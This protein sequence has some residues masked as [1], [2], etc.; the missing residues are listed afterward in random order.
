M[1]RD[2]SLGN[3]SVGDETSLHIN[4]RTDYALGEI[5]FPQVGRENQTGGRVWRFGVWVDGAFAWSTDPTFR[6]ALRY[7]PE[8][9]VTDVTLENAALDIVLKCADAVDYHRDIYLRKVTL[10][11][12]RSAPR[13]ARLFFHQN[14][15]LKGSERQNTVVYDPASRSML[16]YR[17]DRWVLAGASNGT[18]YGVDHYGVGLKEVQGLEGV[19]RACETGRLGDTAVQHGSVDSAVELDVELGPSETRTVYFYLCFGVSEAAVRE[20]HQRLVALGPERILE[21]TANFWRVWVTAHR[22]QFADLPEGLVALYRRSLL[23]IRTQ[24]DNSGAIIAAVD[25]DVASDIRENYSYCWTR[26]G[27]LVAYALQRAGYEPPSAAFFDFCLRVLERE[28][29]PYFMHKYNPDDTVASTWLPRVGPHREPRLPI[30]EDE[31]ALV[32][33]SLWEHYA[34]FRQMT[35][36]LREQVYRMVFP[37][38]D[39]IC[40]FRIDGLPCATYDLWEERFGVHLYTAAAVY[41][42]LRAARDFAAVFAEETRLLRYRQAA[43]EVRDAIMTKFWDAERG[44]LLRMLSVDDQGKPG[45]DSP[46]CFVVDSAA[47][48]VFQFGVLRPDDPRLIATMEK[49]RTRLWVNTEVGGVAR[50]ERDGYQQ[51][52]HNDFARVPG[53]PWF[54][55]TLWLAEWDIARARTRLELAKARELLLWVSKRALPSGVL[56]EQVDPYSGAPLSVSPLTW[57]HATFVTVVEAYV[58]AYGRLA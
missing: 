32:L 50:Y 4:F 9:L 27:A 5:Y 39:W 10:V 35:H 21:R 12:R 28:G 14:P 11:N 44:H 38:A 40:D 13:D 47:S 16:C 26:D 36:A 55:C 30:Q 3:Q 33:W 54:I 46:D 18:S 58:A 43:D 41:G 37:C 7:R 22:H 42:A 6:R 31:T 57:S 2:L 25:W 29:R 17:S 8:T 49:I 20:H 52:E 15:F 48:A 56:A 34:R 51:V 1:P 19:W 45:K 23:T 53:N 24:A